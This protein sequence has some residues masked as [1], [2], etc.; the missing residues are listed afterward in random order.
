MT[1]YL[2]GAG[3]GDPGLLTRRGAA[4]LAAADVVV[5][6]RLVDRALLA[7]AP[8]DA[9][10]VDVGKV[11]GRGRTTEDGSTRQAQI[12]R[13]LVERGRAGRCVVR[14]KGGDPFLFGRGGEEAEAL[15]AAGVD[16]EVVPGVT[17]ALAVP[18]VAGVP[19]THRG[20]S[21]SVTVVTGHVGD[22]TAPG[23][24]D[25][26]S[27][28]RA[29]GTLVV[30]M[31]MANRAEIARRLLGAGRPASTPVAVVT[32]GTTDAQRTARTTL[33]QLAE[34]ALG[35]PAVIV[36]GDVAALDLRP[37]ARASAPADQPLAGTPVVVT[38][39]RA[40]G[41]ELV[42][43]LEGAGARVLSVPAIEV[44]DPDDGGAALRAALRDLA[45]YRWI[46]F[47]SAN[48]VDRTVPLARDGR[49][50]AGVGLAAV[51]RATAAALARYGL[52]ADLVPGRA[53]AD[54]LVEEFPAPDA[55]SAGRAARVLFPCAVDAR[56][57]LPA[58]LRAKGW[59]VEDVVAY[60]TVPAPPPPAAMLGPLSDAAAIVFSSPSAV[61]AYLGMR[62]DTLT[63]AQASPL[64]VPPVVVCGGP[65]T[66][67]S[68]RDAG[69]E[70]V[71]ETVVEASGPSADAILRTLVD[72]LARPPAAPRVPSS[73]ES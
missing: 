43:V 48:A 11:P 13:L 53:R 35:S 65:T 31:G 2:V 21:T 67:A 26:E 47:T 49:S 23:G 14:L 70:R 32:W 29:G 71:V 6:D 20:L 39:P 44:H 22:A 12:N 45:R 9:E 25:W 57:T 64:P 3:P 24:V 1:V 73:L 28:G 37:G 56:P 19:V 4:L 72:A 69:L 60:R 58:G 34:V 33:G 36:I 41:E 61:H 51:G 59:D 55:A 5:Y 15:D 54:A 50:F 42:A 63:G 40:S 52:V 38:R 17:S 62:V 8:E 66:A 68:A 10:L 30:L 16:W 27:L 7:L 46:V 18:A